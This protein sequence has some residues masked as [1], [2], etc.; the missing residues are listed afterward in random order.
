LGRMKER[1]NEKDID[2][3]KAKAEVETLNPKP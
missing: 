3:L 1:L 2:L